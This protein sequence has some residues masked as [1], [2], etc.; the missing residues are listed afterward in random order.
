MIR[1]NYYGNISKKICENKLNIRFN[2]W[3]IM[4]NHRQ[5]RAINKYNKSI[6]ELNSFEII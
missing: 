2:Q 6:K 1:K 4:S 5:N 3:K